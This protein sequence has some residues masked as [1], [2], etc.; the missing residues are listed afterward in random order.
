[1]KFEGRQ[2]RQSKIAYLPDLV[3]FVLDW[4]RGGL[5][6][7]G[8]IES[9]I[10]FCV[11]KP[12]ELSISVFAVSNDFLALAHQAHIEF[13]KVPILIELQFFQLHFLLL[14]HDHQHQHFFQLGELFHLI[15]EGFSLIRREIGS[16]D[17]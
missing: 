16:K 7:E 17:L 13:N 3:A 9:V 14:H 11:I 8:E 10:K 12:V 1:M 5:E 6:L 4:K 15:L 2:R